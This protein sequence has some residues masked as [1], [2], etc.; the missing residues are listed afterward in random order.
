ML[1]SFGRDSRDPFV[2]GSVVT[3]C[4]LTLLDLPANI[5]EGFV[6][7]MRLGD[8]LVRNNGG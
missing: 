3:H 2:E 7:N 5:G 1:E 8:D 6:A 4:V